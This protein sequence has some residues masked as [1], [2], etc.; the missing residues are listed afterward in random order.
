MRRQQDRDGVGVGTDIDGA[1][2]GM[3]KGS[4]K[5]RRSALVPSERHDWGRLFQLD[6]VMAGGKF[7]GGCIVV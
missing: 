1:G 6:D 2:E 4:P 7:Y 3:A 5:A